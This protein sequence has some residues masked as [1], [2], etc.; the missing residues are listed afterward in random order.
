MAVA[1]AAAEYSNC[2]HVIW[3]MI[4]L[5]ALLTKKP[6]TARTHANRPDDPGSAN[7]GRYDSERLT[8]LNHRDAALF[9]RQRQV[10][11]FERQRF[12][13]E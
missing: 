9:H 2:R 7:F 8:A 5:W 10:A 4:N 12:F 3:P 13:A 6:I 1:N 11:V